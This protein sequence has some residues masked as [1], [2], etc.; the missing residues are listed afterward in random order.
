MKHLKSFNEQFTGE[1][2]MKTPEPKNI[3]VESYNSWEAWQEAVEN[4]PEFQRNLRQ[5]ALLPTSNKWDS[6]TKQ[7]ENYF[8]NYMKGN[9]L[10]NV[11]TDKSST[12]FKYFGFF[13]SHDGNVSSAYDQTD[14][15]VKADFIQ[16]YLDQ[17]GIDK[18]ELN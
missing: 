1:D 12:P 7:A 2:Q 18:K 16:T 5:W 15:P 14:R 3:E 11:I 13:L 10:F 17:A 4:S 9:K 6:T 8:K